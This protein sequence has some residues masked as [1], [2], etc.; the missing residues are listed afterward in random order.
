M[1]SFNIALVV[2]G[3]L[4]ETSGFVEPDDERYAVPRAKGCFKCAPLP[5]AWPHAVPAVRCLPPAHRLPIGPLAL[6]PCVIS[7]PQVTA[8]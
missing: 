4:S 5:H 7:V 2:K 3:S 8:V 1:K 6:E